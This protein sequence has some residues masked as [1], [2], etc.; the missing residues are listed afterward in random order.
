MSQFSDVISIFMINMHSTYGC[1]TVWALMMISLL[2]KKPADQCP[3][4]CQE[5]IEF[6]K[7]NVICNVSLLHQIL[8]LND[9]I[10]V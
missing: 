4:C 2:H 1:Q 8:Y 3:H 7:K 6:E 5:G 10:H 9:D